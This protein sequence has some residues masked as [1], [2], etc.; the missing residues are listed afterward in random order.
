MRDEKAMTMPTHNRASP[1]RDEESITKNPAMR[2]MSRRR[3][4]FSGFR[5]NF[6]V[7]FIPTFH[8]GKDFKSFLNSGTLLI[9]KEKIS[10]LNYM[11]VK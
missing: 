9:A 4:A 10:I 8:Q 1:K 6:I 7:A 3:W 5:K 2:M 11:K